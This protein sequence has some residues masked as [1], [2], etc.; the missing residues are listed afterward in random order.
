MTSGVQQPA[1][2][3]VGGGVIGL[4]LAY[5]L[6][7]RSWQVTLL[8]R[9]EVG[10]EAS[11]A[12]AGILPPANHESAHHPL[13][14]LAGLTVQLHPTWARRLADETGIDTGYRRCGGLYLALTSGEVAALHGQAATWREEQ[15]A[16]ER[17]T[18]DELKTWEPALTEPVES[19]AIKA[20]YR[21]PDE[22][23]LRNPRHLAALAQA[24]RQRGVRLVEQA[25]V[26]GFRTR[27]S[28]IAAVVTSQGEFS[29]DQVCLTAGAWSSLLLRDL[30][31][32]TGVLPIRGQMILFRTERP[33]LQQIVS[34][35]PRYLVPRDDGRLLAGSTEEDVGFAPETTAEGLQELQAFATRLVP[36]LRDAQIE[37]TWTGLRPG[38]YD[39]LPYLGQLPGWSNLVVAAG[40]FRNGLYLSPATAVVIADLLE[41]RPPPIDLRLFRVSRG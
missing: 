38:T 28:R 2:V 25:A 39:G 24:C 27:G 40:H 9:R 14:Q 33:L 32:E 3:I 26:T 29:G 12:G 22:A 35:G 6:V 4:S 17:L 15:I 23:Q 11:W 13:E 30:G 10:R 16:V 41:E 5:E 34:A 37:R 7:T 21:L 1:A 18:L 31:V 36:S 19:R 8:E 20:A